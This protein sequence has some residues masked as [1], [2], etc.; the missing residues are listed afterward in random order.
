[1]YGDSNDPDLNGGV[2]GTSH[3]AV[4]GPADVQLSPYDTL[5]GIGK[6]LDMEFGIAVTDQGVSEPGVNEESQLT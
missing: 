4:T 3:K 6:I 5:T 1:M 2:N